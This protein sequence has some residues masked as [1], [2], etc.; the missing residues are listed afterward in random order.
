[1]V[2]V[3]FCELILI[4]LRTYVNYDNIWDKLVFQPRRSRIKVT[5]AFGG[6]GIYHL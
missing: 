4:K 1:M 2:S 6:G 3:L 5:V